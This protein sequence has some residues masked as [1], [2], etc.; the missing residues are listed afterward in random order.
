MR[1]VVCILRVLFIIYGQASGVLIPPPTMVWFGTGGGG[2]ACVETGGGLGVAT[3]WWG[4]AGGRYCR[5]TAAQALRNL[6]YSTCS[7]FD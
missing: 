3:G 6:Q 5:G 7:C 1:G 4:D 2:L